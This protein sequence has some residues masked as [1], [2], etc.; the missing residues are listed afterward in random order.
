MP[1]T[2]TVHYPFH[3]LHD[4]CLDVVVWP[5]QATQAVTV[6]PIQDPAVDATT[7]GGGL[8]SR[9]TR[10]TARHYSTGG[11]GYVAGVL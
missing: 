4:Y 11:G 5:R 6:R 10:S 8:L 2:V 9:S 7:R 3:P 1:S